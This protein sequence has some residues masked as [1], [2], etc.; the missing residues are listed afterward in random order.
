MIIIIIQ[1]QTPTTEIQAPDFG[2]AHNEYGGLKLVC[3]L[4]P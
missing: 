1:Q 4:F 3:Q 2:K